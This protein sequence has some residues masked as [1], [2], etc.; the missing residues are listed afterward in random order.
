MPTVIG[1]LT[2]MSRKNSILGSMSLKKL[3]FLILLYFE[4]LKFHAQL[5]LWKCLSKCDSDRA[6]PCLPRPAHQLF[7]FKHLG[8]S[9]TEVKYRNVRLRIEFEIVTFIL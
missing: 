5:S 3:H 7:S 4:H 9:N 6:D 2:I 8:F 1:I